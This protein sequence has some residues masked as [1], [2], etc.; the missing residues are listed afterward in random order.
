MPYVS[1]AL[2]VGGASRSLERHLAVGGRVNIYRR[3]N[4]RYWQCQATFDGQSRRVSARTE[5]LEEAR[6]F[7]E[8]WYL[9]KVEQTEALARGRETA[10]SPLSSGGVPGTSRSAIHDKRA[11][12][13]LAAVDLVAEVGFKNAQ[14]T[15]IADRSGLAAGTLYRHFGSRSAI[16]IEVVARVSQHEVNVIAGTAMGPGS[17]EEILRVCAQTFASRALRG[18]RLGHALVAEPVE[19]EI[20][21]E[22]LGY[23]RKL[24]RIFETVIERG[25]R[26][27]DFP[28]QDPEISAACIVGS[29]FEAL[30][31]PLARDVQNDE[32][33]RLEL[34][35]QIAEFC[36]RGVIGR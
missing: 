5:S 16:L 13:I 36:V 21:V 30:V 17:S 34:A 18:R 7:A 26:I 10:R 20:E 1:R 2:G 33:Q 14:I 15:A 8:A 4:S 25:M 32:P 27:G 19:E 23:R 28:E 6:A 22:R 29:L 11:R 24:M 35:V 9:S 12:I 3:P 31:G